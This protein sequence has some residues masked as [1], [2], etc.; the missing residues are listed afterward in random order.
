[1][2]VWKRHITALDDDYIREKAL[3]GPDTTTRL[4]TLWQVRLK[5]VSESEC[6]GVD[7]GWAQGSVQ[8]TGKLQA[9]QNILWLTG[10]K[11]CNTKYKGL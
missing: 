1:M 6:S 2:D 3:G 4:K 10:M 11:P 8:S 7:P 9:R 5:A